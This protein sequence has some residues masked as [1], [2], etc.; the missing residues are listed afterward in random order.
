MKK[1]HIRKK[2]RQKAKKAQ[3]RKNRIV[4][5]QINKIIKHRNEER[6]KIANLLGMEFSPQEN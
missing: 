6:S 5:E 4:S 2:N 3:E 1:D